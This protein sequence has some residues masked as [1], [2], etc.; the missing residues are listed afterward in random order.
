VALS[1]FGLAASFGFY[2]GMLSRLSPEPTLAAY[3][4]LA[5]DNEPL[6]VLDAAVRGARYYPGRELLLFPSRERAARFI[7]DG[8]ARNGSPRRFL[9]LES[10]ELAAV[11][12]LFRAGSVPRKDLPIV[13]WNSGQWA[14]GASSLPPGERDR[15]PFRNFFSTTRPASEHA[16]SIEFGRKLELAGWS[17]QAADRRPASS[18]IAGQTYE[19]VLHF[20]VAATIGEA[21]NIFVH[22]D[23]LQQR[24]NADHLPLDGLYPTTFWLA[25]DWVTD[26]HR[27]HL[28]ASLAPGTYGLYVGMY[29]GDARV[30]VTRGSAE[31]DRIFL[32]ALRID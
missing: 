8:P 28:D 24:F 16:V 32:G 11:N 20:Y 4:R 13:E 31:A 19:L 14:L 15:S 18:L 27:M 6:G 2:P 26:R 29:R 3:E 7:A 9:A 30:P 21:W 12:A 25:G 23:G 17:F 5:R 22:L 10:S 1:V